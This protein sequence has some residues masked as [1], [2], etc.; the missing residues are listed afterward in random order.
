MFLWERE[1][2]LDVKAYALIS[3]N[4][5]QGLLYTGI[6][7]VKLYL[8]AQ[9]IHCLTSGSTYYLVGKVLLRY[10]IGVGIFWCLAHHVVCLFPI[11]RLLRL[12]TIDPLTRDTPNS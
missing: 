2:R 10:L 9:L 12:N 7:E 3:R 11:W 4:S 8:V 6:N 1:K 5:N